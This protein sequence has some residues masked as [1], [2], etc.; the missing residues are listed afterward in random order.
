MVN[1]EEKQYLREAVLGYLA[2]S[3][4]QR[5]EPHP[6]HTLLQRRKVVDFPF[7]HSDLDEALAVLEGLGFVE[8]VK[9]RLGAI[10]QFMAS[11]EGVIF[12]E[13]SNSP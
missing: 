4:G 8:R 1:L 7:S 3:P 12:H 9:S 2:R 13:Q 5:Y 6:L 10:P 11:A